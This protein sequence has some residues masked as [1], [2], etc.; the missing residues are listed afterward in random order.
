M[1]RVML[2]S[3]CLFAVLFTFA[4]VACNN[5][6]ESHVLG[7]WIEGKEATCSEAGY[8]GHYHCSHCDK[9]FD[10]DGNEI[11]ELTIPKL[12]HDPIEVPAQ[13]ATCTEPGYSSGTKCL[14]C[15][16]YITAHKTEDALGHQPK[17]V[18]GRKATCTENGV[19]DCYEC[20]RCHKFS[21][22]QDGTYDGDAKEDVQVEIA[23]SHSYGEWIVVSGATCTEAGEQKRVCE[24]CDHEDIA[25]I[26]KIAHSSLLVAGKPATCTEAGLSDCYVCTMCGKYSA[27]EDGDYTL[28]LIDDARTTLPETGHD[29]EGSEW[30]EVEAPTCQKAGQKVRRCN[31]CSEKEVAEVEALP[32]TYGDWIRTEEP[33]CTTLGMET[34]SCTTC[35]PAYGAVASK[36]RTVD[37]VDHKFDDDGWVVQTE[38][39][40]TV[41]GTETNSCTMCGIEKQTR[42]IETKPHTSVEIK[43]KPATCTQEG[44]T[45]GESCSVCGQ[46]LK[47][48]NTI[49]ALGHTDKWTYTRKDGKSDS[50][51]LD[52]EYH[53]KF[54]SNVGC[55]GVTELCEITVK[56]YRDDCSKPGTSE[57]SCALCGYKSTEQLAAGAHSWDGGAVTTPATCNSDG[58]MTYKC[59]LCSQTMQQKILERPAHQPADGWVVESGK[60]FHKCKEC[61]TRLDEAAHISTDWIVDKVASCTSEG[62]AHKE[63][64][65]CKTQ[66]ETDK[67]EKL[68]HSLTSEWM[69]S[70]DKHYHECLIC[71]EHCD[72]QTHQSSVLVG[73]PATCEQSGL[74]DGAECSICHYI[75]TA[76]D[77]IPAKNHSYGK[78]TED[79]E[80]PNWHKRVCENDPNHVEYQSCN[81]SSTVVE[82]T[83]LADGYTLQKCTECG[84]EIKLNIQSALGHSY[85][86]YT[87]VTI[88]EDEAGHTHMHYADCTR[89]G[90]PDARITEECTLELQQHFAATCTAAGYDLKVCRMCNAN[91]EEITEMAKGHTLSYNHR[92]KG[93]IFEC[94]HQA[95]CTECDYVGEYED[96]TPNVTTVQATCT[97]PR[98]AHYICAV[99]EIGRV[100]PYAEQPLGH[101]WSN[102]EFCGTVDEPQHKYVCMRDGCDEEKVESCDIQSTTQLPT[103]EAAGSVTS[104]C[105]VCMHSHSKEGDAS[106]GHKWTLWSQTSDGHYRQCLNCGE[107]EHEE[108]EMEVISQT[109]ANCEQLG[110]IV[111]QCKWCNME[112]RKVSGEITKHKWL[113]THFDENTHIATCQQCGLQ[114]SQSHDWSQSNLCSVCGVDGLTYKIEGV[115]CYVIGDNKV[116]NAKKIII[117][118]KYRE[119]DGNGDYLPTEYTVTEIRDDAFMNNKAVEE[120]VL[121]S[122]LQKICS[123]AFYYCS[124]LRNVTVDGEGKNLTDIESYAFAY[125][126]ALTSFIPPKSILRVGDYAFINCTSLTKIDIGDQLEDIGKSAFLN[127]GYVNNGEHWT[128]DILYIGKHLIKV[129]QT[130]Q[131]DG[132]MSNTEVVVKDGTVSISAEAFVGCTTL[133]KVTL[134]ASLKTVDKD[135]FRDCTGITE[136]DYLGSFNEWLSINFLSDYS[137]PLHYG[138]PT[139]HIELASDDIVIPEGVTRIPAGTFRGTT[140]KSVSLPASLTFIG[141][142][143]FENCTDLTT[144]TVNGDAKI[145]Y[146]GKDAFVGSGYY[147]NGSNWDNGVVLYVGNYLIEAKDTITG[148]YTVKDGTIAI[149][150]DAFLGCKQLTGITL[151]KELLF[152]GEGAFVDCDALTTIVFT[153]TN[154]RWFMN[155]V[156]GRSVP[157][158]STEWRY[159]KIYYGAWQRS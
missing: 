29:Y 8:V 104:A 85:G 47:A 2:F 48:Q 6:G 25:V 95:Y 127:T 36:T 126:G 38:A 143:A 59:T 21:L 151:S 34:S 84:D 79:P 24:V 154:Y 113:V 18:D 123:M 122:T 138:N 51:S 125:C 67:L 142:E 41:Q 150:N 156:I 14:R 157:V 105:R 102:A 120:V 11:D 152:V 72:E 65:V 20:E 114:D 92:T 37:K 17:L 153:E 49:P 70:G 74:T 55:P 75:I 16:D 93:S 22:T 64:S 111:E 10:R 83:C 106:V 26:D 54:C 112:T 140:I 69:I 103:C 30:Q 147:L 27:T 50:K 32:H 35:D 128:D 42:L 97:K 129:R 115:H 159:Y 61:G 118:E 39:T 33:T 4:L 1:K 109:E 133:G 13:P 148:S 53:I 63:C 31:N 137:S 52:D 94:E 3:A 5:T 119:V 146:I 100:I 81:Y 9:D 15:G 71:H 40:C 60:H 144:I 78:W 66:L 145:S 121:P 98:E 116:S 101:L 76:Q 132:T 149:A 86:S 99:C 82:A 131:A 77:F 107:E 135:A 117:R 124:K 136:V 73:S 23:A 110:E 87:S 62:S 44:S 90:A 130:E 155:G 96:C 134:P 91:H 57:R 19:S 58:L 43:G 108:H 68:E 28:D 88:D 45:D 12:G 7:E 46:I 89:C 141:E 139:F 158:T 56:D 80:K